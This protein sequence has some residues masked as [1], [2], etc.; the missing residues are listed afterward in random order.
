MLLRYQ[1]CLVREPLLLQHLQLSPHAPAL[2]A[3][4]Y[5]QQLAHS[6]PQQQ[7]LLLQAFTPLRYPQPLHPLVLLLCLLPCLVLLQEE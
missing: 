5:H 2:V 1:Q 6:C 7:H 4:L 3:H